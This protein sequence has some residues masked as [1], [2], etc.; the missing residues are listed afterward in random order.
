MAYY[1]YKLSVGNDWV[2]K[3]LAARIDERSVPHGSSTRLHP[4]KFL[5]QSRLV[6]TSPEVCESPGRS[7]CGK[8]LPIP[9]PTGFQPIQDGQGGLGKQQIAHFALD[10]IASF[11]QIIC[12]S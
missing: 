3:R 10:S 9:P 12:C 2:Q 11:A 4:G 1:F 8:R 7:W 5:W 6:T